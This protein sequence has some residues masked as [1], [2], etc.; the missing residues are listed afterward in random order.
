MINASNSSS[1]FRY[2]STIY[3]LLPKLMLYMN[4]F[5]QVTR[6][7]KERWA[8]SP[9]CELLFNESTYYVFITLLLS[10]SYHLISY[11]VSRTR[12]SLAIKM[13]VLEWLETLY[14]WSKKIY[15]INRCI[16]HNPKYFMILSNYQYTI[17]SLP[18]LM[19]HVD[20]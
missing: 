1:H 14:A 4:K 8:S 16:C 12:P 6:I 18:R 11:R 17:A 15:L 9:Y 19:F 13:D 3:M 2:R 7:K 10:T 5:S 20:G